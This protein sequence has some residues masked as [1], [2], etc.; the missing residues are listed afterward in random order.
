MKEEPI[1][2]KKETA[3]NFKKLMEIVQPDD[4]L[5]LIM[6]G[7]PDPDAIASA[8]ALREIIQKT[9][10]LSKSAFVS[11][12]PLIR[13]Q[14][15]EF[16]SSLHLYI[17]LIN[18]IDIESFRLI[19]VLDAQPSFF[20]KSFNFIKPQIVFDHH[21]YEG[22]WSAEL[23]DI[24][25]HYGALSS[26]LTE[27]L[28]YSR[29]KITRNLHTALLYGIKTDTDNFNRSTIIED[30]SAY[31]YH[32]KYANMQFIRRIELNQTP[33]CFLKYFNYAY[34]HMNNFRGRRVCFLGE[35][36]SADV[37]V[38]VADFYLRLI[39]TYYV[40]V[41]GIIGDRLV[42]IFRGDGYRQNCG[43]MAQRAFGLIGKGGGH[44]SAARMEIDLD[45]LKE[46]LNDD[47][48]QRN[49]EKFL[50]KSLRR[51]SRQAPGEV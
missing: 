6:H 45:L 13:Q 17:Q 15:I 32:T 1:P 36:E 5:L 50:F 33:D 29:V 10:G 19:A 38:Q 26:I 44:K 14:N 41:A 7:S 30:I 20:S 16:V 4:S 39:G 8:M 12:E 37:C 34:H 11:T 3:M 40:V 43:D 46:N 31:N 18:Q 9:K 25:P 23:A 28:V 35:V 48:S 42:I 27:Y 22:Q 49:V 47:L 24:R 21:P 51:E 2:I